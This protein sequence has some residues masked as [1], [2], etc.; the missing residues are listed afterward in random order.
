VKNPNNFSVQVK[1][2]DC[3]LLFSDSVIGGL[4]TMEDVRVTRK[5]SVRMP[6]SFY[7][8]L[9]ALGKLVFSDSWFLK[10]DEKSSGFEVR[11]E[12][13]LRKFIFTRKLRWS[14]KV[15]L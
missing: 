5:E 1:N 15:Q 6:I 9:S 4:K 2:L 13:K 14:E 7:P 12:M 10:K 8:N 11:G 3:K